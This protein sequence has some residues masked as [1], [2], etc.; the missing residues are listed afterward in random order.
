M[1]NGLRTAVFMT[2]LRDKKAFVFAC[3]VPLPGTACPKWVPGSHS[4][5]PQ[6]SR[7]AQKAVHGVGWCVLP[8][9]PP[10]PGSPFRVPCSQLL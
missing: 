9:A 4:G 10:V 1:Q 7:N 5:E 3:R 2:T 8:L 6:R